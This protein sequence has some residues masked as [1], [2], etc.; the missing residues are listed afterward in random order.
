MKLGVCYYPEHWPE[1]MWKADAAEMRAMGIA[2]ARIG[3]FAWSRIEPQR[4]VFD[5]GWLDRAIDTLHQAGVQVVLG[6]PSATP[7]RW[8]IAERPDILAVDAQGRTRGFGSR[9]HYCFSNEFYRQAA[10]EMAARLAE[11]YGRHPAV[12]GWQTDNEYGCHATVLSYSAAA[13]AAFRDWCAAKYGDI[14]TLN[15]AW[16]NVFWSMEYADFAEID[17]PAGTVTEPNPAHVLDWR[18]FSSDQVVRFNR[19]Q[20]DAIRKFAP[21]VPISHNAMGFSTDFDHRAL[22][23]DLDEIGWDSYPLGFLDKFGFPEDQKRAFART[24]HPDLAAFHHD[25]YRGLGAPSWGVMEQQPGPVNWAPHNPAPLPG[26]VRLWTLEAMA[27]GADFVSYFR[28][29]QYPRAQ[30]QMHA[31]LKRPDD[32]LAQGGREAAR[33]AGEIA[34]LPATNTTPAPVA[35]IF[36][37]ESQWLC[38]TQPQGENFSHIWLAFAWYCA[39]RRQGFDIDILGRDADLSGYRLV[40]VPCLPILDEATVERFAAVEGIVLCGPRTGSKT[41]DFGIPAELAPGAL[42]RRMG[43]VVAAV[44]SLRGDA[45]IAVSGG[46]MQGNFTIWR[47]QAV[48]AGAEILAQTADGAPALLRRDRLHYLAGWAD[49]ALLDSLFAALA[50]QAGLQPQRLAPGLRLRRRGDLCFAF[51]LGPEPA[52]APVPANAELLLGETTLAAGQAAIWRV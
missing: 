44:E 17:P 45:A 42:G 27:H 24:G 10:A 9:R 19:A 23:G 35:L 5:W 4:G 8:L 20:V 47:E 49:D 28:W 30:E 22:A 2:F 41:A 33:V 43:F 38:E 12:T 7:P 29:R 14:A 13:A 34:A 46:G 11:R 36:D 18:R 52:S 15:A 50:P 6:T 26:M 25:L 51:N 3:E 1:D 21:K 40:V 32:V 48:P 37:Y 39:L 16:G 31:G